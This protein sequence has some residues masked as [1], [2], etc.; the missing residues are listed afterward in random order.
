MVGTSSLGNITLS[1]ATHLT[2]ASS[3]LRPA[4]LVKLKVWPL[5]ASKA[6]PPPSQYLPPFWRIK[7]RKMCL[8]GWGQPLS[9][10]SPLAAGFML[11]SYSV[12]SEASLMKSAQEVQPGFL[13]APYFLGICVVLTTTPPY[14]R[15][16]SVGRPLSLPLQV[17]PASGAAKKV[18]WA[19]L[20]EITSS[21]TSR[22][23][24][25]K[26]HTQEGGT[27]TRSADSLSCF[28]SAMR[29]EVSVG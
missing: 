7:L 24:S 20:S 27:I 21:G 14:S 6:S 3:D 23:L 17:E 18:F 10:S 26:P 5:V 4:S 12:S 19:S 16:Y 1:V 29:V 2:M 9:M 13:P 25:A 11:A 15:L 28:S 22:M 8:T